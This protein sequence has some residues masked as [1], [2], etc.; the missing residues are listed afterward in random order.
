MIRPQ[1]VAK[2]VHKYGLLRFF[3]LVLPPLEA[4]SMPEAVDVWT[5]PEAKTTE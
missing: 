1:T 3:W 2:P 5:S 4:A